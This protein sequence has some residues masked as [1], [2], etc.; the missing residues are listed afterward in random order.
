MFLFFAVIAKD[1]D[2]RRTQLKVTFAAV[3]R[4]LVTME[5]GL[6]VFVTGGTGAIGRHAVPALV[7]MGYTVT[8]LARTADKAALLQNQGAIPVTVSIFDRAALT[9]AF[10]GYDAV[11]NLA[12][13]IPPTAKFMQ[14]KAWAENIRVRTEGSVAIVD[15]AIAAGVPRVL[16]ESV[17]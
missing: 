2:T 8:E 6:K 1:E 12:T 16:Q 11:I 9:E 13:A 4:Y 5:V 14:T 7:G 15:A 3:V 17:S 10:V